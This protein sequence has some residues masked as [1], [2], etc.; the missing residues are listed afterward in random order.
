MLSLVRWCQFRL[1]RQRGL[2]A[3]YH[4]Q[5]EKSCR[6]RDQELITEWMRAYREG[7]ENR[8]FDLA[9]GTHPDIESIHKRRRRA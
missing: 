1:A 3:G 8:R 9:E 5:S 6:Y 7:A 4:G 2:E